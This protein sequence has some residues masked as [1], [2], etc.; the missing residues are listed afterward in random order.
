MTV[1]DLPHNISSSSANLSNNLLQVITDKW[2]M[3]NWDE[4]IKIADNSHYQQA[5]FY[6]CQNYMRIEMSPVGFVMAD[7]PRRYEGSEERNTRQKIRCKL[8]KHFY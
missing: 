3:F 4:F 5:N 8:I 1:L 2:L 6:Y 7:E